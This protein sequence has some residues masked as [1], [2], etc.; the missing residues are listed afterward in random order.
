MAWIN[1]ERN[2][3]VFGADTR[4][5]GYVFCSTTSLLLYE[6]W[7]CCAEF[8]HS[9]EKPEAAPYLHW[10]SS[11]TYIGT[12]TMPEWMLILW[13]IT[14][15]ETMTYYELTTRRPENYVGYNIASYR[16]F[17]E[18]NLEA[19]QDEGRLGRLFEPHHE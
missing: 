19:L 9:L 12:K 8:R 7:L 5:K 15:E 10:T 14:A 6:G 2:Y 17:P 3:H 16:I 18:K 4:D 11:M 1:M 13:E